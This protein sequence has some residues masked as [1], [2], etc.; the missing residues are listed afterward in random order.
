MR[1]LLLFLICSISLVLSSLSAASTEPQY[2]VAILDRFFPPAEGFSSEEER[3]HHLALYGLDDL[4]ND[5]EA[6]PI[7]H[8]DLVRMLAATQQVTFIN[9]PIHHNQN[10]MG[11]ILANLQK[12]NARMA[13]SPVDALVLSWESSTL[14]STF[15][16]PL[17]REH[18]ALYKEKVRQMGE[19][20]PIWRDTWLIIKELEKLAET[21][22]AVYTIAG[23]GGRRMIN[24]FSLA[25]GVIT[26]GA[27]EEELQHYVANNVFVDTY[28]R[29]AYLLKRID[30]EAGQPLGYDLDADNCVDIPL[31]RLTGAGQQSRDAYPKT[32]W[33]VL[34]GSSF[35]A[36]AALKAALAGNKAEPCS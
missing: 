15:P 13:T 27:V 9:Y 8:G 28:A 21:G 34:K 7:Y 4:D 20:S 24:T 6:E 2:K 12:I 32:Y 26:V 10:P 5:S 35:A 29:A 22:V 25:N 14:I 11:D 33:K 3:S 1:Q 18:A 19:S 17:K 23:N 31:A 36:P 16:Q 30:N